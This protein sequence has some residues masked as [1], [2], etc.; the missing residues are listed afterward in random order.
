MT[1]TKKWL[2]GGL[3]FMGLYSLLQDNSGKTTAHNQNIQQQETREHQQ[4]SENIYA[5]EETENKNWAKEIDQALSDDSQEKRKAI[6][7]SEQCV[8]SKGILKEGG[9][10]IHFL[11]SPFPD[12]KKADPKTFSDRKAVLFNPKLTEFKSKYA[13]PSPLF[14]ESEELLFY[15][16]NG[17]MAIGNLANELM[18]M[19]NAKTSK[20]KSKHKENTKV[21]RK[22]IQELENAIKEKCK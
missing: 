6:S 8:I 19:V 7:L 16:S 14:A 11:I 17:K 21:Y 12:L 5:K 3:C 1:K 20:E 2:I 13:F 22:F 15:A 18:W 4:E 9:E 10:L